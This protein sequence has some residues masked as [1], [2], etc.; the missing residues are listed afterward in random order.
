M[1]RD[2]LLI[3]SWIGFANLYSSIAGSFKMSIK[4]EIL[5]KSNHVGKQHIDLYRKLMHQP[6]RT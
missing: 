4:L 6:K 3:V 1:A 2:L 5:L